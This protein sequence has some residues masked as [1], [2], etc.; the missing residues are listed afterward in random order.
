MH[1][2]EIRATLSGTSLNSLDEFY[3]WDKNNSADIWHDFGIFCKAKVAANEMR[4]LKKE[5]F[6]NSGQVYIV[7]MY[8]DEE[9]QA[10]SF[11]SELEASD[12][13][14]DQIDPENTIYTVS[15][16]ISSVTPLQT[17]GA[18]SMSGDWWD[19]PALDVNQ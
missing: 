13:W 12:F 18:N 7:N 5:S 16:S 15:T 19:N 17:G 8:F 3:V 14:L 1:T 6:N 10:N 11:I 2:L 4:D 9:S